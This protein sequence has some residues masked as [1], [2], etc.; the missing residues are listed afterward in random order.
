[1]ISLFN[2]NIGVTEVKRVMRPRGQQTPMGSEVD[3]LRE[4]FLFPVARQI[5]NDWDKKKFNEN[6]WLFQSSYCL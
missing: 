3:T 5:L 2:R 6:L 4:H 1:M